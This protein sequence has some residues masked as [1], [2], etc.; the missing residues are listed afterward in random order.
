[1]AEFS[2]LKINKFTGSEGSYIW[3]IAEVGLQLKFF[4]IKESY[5]NGIVI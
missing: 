4:D 2:N 3:N 5:A 1:M